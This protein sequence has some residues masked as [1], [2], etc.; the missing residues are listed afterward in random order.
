MGNRGAEDV[1][2]IKEIDRLLTLSGITEY[3]ITI[4]GNEQYETMGAFIALMDGLILITALL[5]S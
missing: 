3:G 4:D 5:N 2:R 1:N